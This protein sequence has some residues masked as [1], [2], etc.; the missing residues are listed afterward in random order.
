M[1]SQIL[2]SK[3]N[4]SWS[5]PKEL[6]RSLPRDVMIA[7]RGKLLIAISILILGGALAIAVGLGRAASREA[8]EAALLV[9]EGRLADG[10]VTR[11][12][13]GREKS[14]QPWIAY[15]FNAGERTYAR[16]A[17]CPLG[18]WRQWEVGS[19]IRIR[20]V[21]SRPEL[22]YPE[23]LRYPVT[24]A[25]IPVAVPLLMILASP[26]IL[27]QIRRQWRLLAE[28][29]VVPATVSR[30]GRMMH[31]SHGEKWGR[32]YY[33]DFTLVSGGSGKGSSGPVKLPPAVGDRITI[34]VDSENPGRNMPYPF[35][36]PLVQLRLPPP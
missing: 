31:G 16:N 35:A 9:A 10:A 15:E 7:W 34:L 25:W 30:I 14:R 5:P 24:P 36:S 2:F 13:R 23:A 21:P 33:Y 29:S 32:K 11:L 18:M 20:Y 17:K 28:G 8:R 4:H 26:L 27:L 12:W 6:D 1:N 3:E 19:P 22:N